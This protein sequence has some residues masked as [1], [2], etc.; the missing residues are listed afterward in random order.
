LLGLVLDMAVMERVEKH[1]TGC[2]A[3]IQSKDLR[4]VGC[5]CGCGCHGVHE[6]AIR[7]ATPVSKGRRCNM[8]GVAVVVVF[9]NY[10]Q[11][12]S[13]G[14]NS[15]GSN[16]KSCECFGVVV[17]VAAREC[18]KKHHGSQFQGMTQRVASA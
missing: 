15:R 6:K 14:R 2:D 16:A 10:T 5:S 4:V 9:R 3:R 8:V 17:A 18:A 12:H 1:C 13:T 7:V 11:M